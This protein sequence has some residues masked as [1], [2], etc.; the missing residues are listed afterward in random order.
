MFYCKE[1][2]DKKEWP[3]SVFRSFGR[4]EVCGKFR[5]CIDTPSKYLPKDRGELKDE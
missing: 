3:D 5:E 1:C 2:R 4:C